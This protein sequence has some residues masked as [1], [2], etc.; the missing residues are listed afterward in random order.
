MPF[1]DQ[2]ALMGLENTGF[3]IANDEPLWIDPLDY[4]DQ[5]AEAVEGLV[6]LRSIPRAVIASKATFFSK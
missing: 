4:R 6:A 3:A 5:L 1:V 2:V